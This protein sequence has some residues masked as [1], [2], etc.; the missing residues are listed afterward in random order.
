MLNILLLPSPGPD[1]V[2]KCP[3]DEPASAVRCLWTAIAGWR[4]NTDAESRAVLF[5]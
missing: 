1:V 5:G 4:L 2:S 3:A